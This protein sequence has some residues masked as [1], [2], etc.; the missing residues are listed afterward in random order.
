MAIGSVL[1]GRAFV[2]GTV[3]PLYRD[4]EVFVRAAIGEVP[5]KYLA[6]SFTFMKAYPCQVDLIA[7]VCSLRANTIG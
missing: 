1:N 4:A 3:T 7:D 2:R 5:S 6:D